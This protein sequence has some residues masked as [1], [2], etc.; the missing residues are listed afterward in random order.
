MALVIS[1]MMN[2]AHYSYTV[3]KG[4]FSCWKVETSTLPLFTELQHISPV[5]IIIVIERTQIVSDM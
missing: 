5:N 2:A 3:S 1:E 4:Y